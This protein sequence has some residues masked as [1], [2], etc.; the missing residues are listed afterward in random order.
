[1]TGK[2]STHETPANEGWGRCI[3]TAR[4]LN[5]DTKRKAASAHRKEA[6][7]FK[8]AQHSNSEPGR[9]WPISCRS[10]NGQRAPSRSRARCSGEASRYSAATHAQNCV[11]RNES[12]SKR[13]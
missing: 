11:Q 10:T 12:E 7:A 4:K 2:Q 13:M 6:I 5:Q 8:I 1:M 9:A 3:K